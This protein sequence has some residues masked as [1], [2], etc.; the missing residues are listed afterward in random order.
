MLSR[1]LSGLLLLFGFLQLVACQDCGPNN[2]PLL[3][4]TL[5]SKTPFRVDTLYGAGATGKLLQDTQQSAANQ[6][7][8]L[9]LNLNADSTRYVL[10]IDGKQEAITVFYQRNFYYR[11]RQCG[12]VYDLLSPSQD[13][14]RQART[15]RGQV[16]AVEYSQ[17]SFDGAF[18]HQAR[19]E[20]GVR[21]TVTL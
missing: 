21:L 16:G 11:S 8:R 15:T 5:Q 10:R 19:S 12:Y 9:P 13:I 6:F 4:L 20:T 14:R 18:L 3:T 17:N 1:L 7:Y 2:E